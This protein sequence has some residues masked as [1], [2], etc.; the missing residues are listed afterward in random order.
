MW[1]EKRKQKKIF[2]RNHNFKKK[3]SQ[4]MAKNYI[5]W[6]LFLTYVYIKLKIKESSLHHLQLGEIINLT[7][8]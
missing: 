1:L 3:N 4:N 2:S 8:M 7:K 5:I 6:Y